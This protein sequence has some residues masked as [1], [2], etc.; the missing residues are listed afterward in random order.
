VIGSIALHDRAIGGQEH[1][2]LV[3]RFCAR[4][5]QRSMI[6]ARAFCARPC[7]AARRAIGHRARRVLSRLG[8]SRAV[9]RPGRGDEAR[10]VRRPARLRALREYPRGHNGN[11]D[12]DSGPLVLGFGVSAT[13]FAARRARMD[14]DA[15]LF[16][17]LFATVQ[18]FARAGRSRGPRAASSPAAPIGNAILFAMLTA[19]RV[20]R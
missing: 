1:A 4:L 6:R 17:S 15:A 16:D 13:G 18:L 2:A 7:R 10:A 5:R 3:A 20:R 9:A 14:G 11:G 12:A 8:R 19:P